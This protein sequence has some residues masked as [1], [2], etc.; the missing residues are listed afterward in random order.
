MARCVL[1]DVVAKRFEHA[2]VD[3]KIRRPG[4]AVVDDFIDTIRLKT[5]D[6][7]GGQ[8]ARE[9]KG[10]FYQAPANYRSRQRAGFDV[11][12]D[13]ATA[14]KNTAGRGPK[15]RSVRAA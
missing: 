2:I 1:A 13:A 15:C 11:R 4:A 3:R 5:E 7:A 8:F 14:I 12:S 10:C 6:R 9:V